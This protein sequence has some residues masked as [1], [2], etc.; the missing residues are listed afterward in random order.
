MILPVTRK[1][2]DE[3]ETPDATNENLE[4]DIVEKI[5]ENMSEMYV[6]TMALGIILH[7][8]R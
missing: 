7:N 2:Q 6:G 5:P 4:A 8:I 1:L 3:N